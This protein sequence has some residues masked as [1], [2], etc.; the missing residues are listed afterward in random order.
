MGIP[1]VRTKLMAF[2]LSGFMAGYAGVCLAFAIQRFNN[3]T[4]FTP[5]TSI[6]IITVVV[7][8]GLGS[9]A[10]AI[11]GAIYL[12]GLP[13]I[14]GTDSTIQFLTGGI[15]VVVFVLYLPGGLAEVMRRAGD[16]AADGWRWLRDRPGSASTPGSPGDAALESVTL[17]DAAS[18][19]AAP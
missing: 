6:H 18:G 15:G 14:F 7:I 13:A 19:G 4:T 8:G 12:I 9:V 3:T 16:L 5:A 2:A 1:V 10:G 17:D 11:L